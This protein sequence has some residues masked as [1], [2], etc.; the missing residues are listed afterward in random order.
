MWSPTSQYYDNNNKG[1]E[2]YIMYGFVTK[3]GYGKPVKETKN[4]PRDH[5]VTNKEGCFSFGPRWVKIAQYTE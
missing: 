5:T 2:A 4:F 1:V 3:Y